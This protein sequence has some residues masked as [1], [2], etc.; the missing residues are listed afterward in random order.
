MLFKPY[1]IPMIRDGEKT[2]TRR[3][4]AENYNRPRAG[5]VH[6]ASTEMFL[7]RDECDCFIRVGEI[8]KEA[9]GEM[10][11]EDAQM[12]GDYDDVDEFVDGWERVNGSGTWDPEQVVDVVPIEYVGR[13][14][15]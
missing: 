2:V 13:T 3:V 12:E 9:L 10:S 1:H 14:A 7:P 8:Y 6:M 5:T 15:P 11:D 4:W